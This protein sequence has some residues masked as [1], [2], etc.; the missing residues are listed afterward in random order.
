MSLRG[1]GLTEFSFAEVYHEVN[2]LRASTR[3]PKKMTRQ[4]MNY[5]LAKLCRQ[6]FIQQRHTSEEHRVQT[7]ERTLQT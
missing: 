6:P 7:R 1:K 3:A 4:T 2:R 5:H